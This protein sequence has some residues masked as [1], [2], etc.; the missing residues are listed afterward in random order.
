MRRA[1]RRSRRDVDIGSANGTFR[2]GTRLPPGEAIQLVVGDTVTLGATILILEEAHE[3]LR[4]IWSEEELVTHYDGLRRAA[5]DTGWPFALVHLSID[6]P[7]AWS[8]D[9]TPRSSE[10]L[11]RARR[12]FGR[13]ISRRAS[14]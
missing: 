4:S 9:A 6:A 13:A 10:D 1:A 14:T 3:P 12:A 8:S 11:V 7:E 5:Q 2:D